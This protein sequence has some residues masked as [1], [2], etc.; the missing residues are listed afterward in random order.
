[1]SQPDL[2]IRQ[3]V[4][5]VLL[6]PS[7]RV[8]LA[9]YDFPTAVVW[10]LPGGGVEADEEPVGALRR[11]LAEELGLVDVEVGPHV[12]NRLHVIPMLD[13]RWD[14]QADQVHLVRTEA[15]TPE[16]QIGWERLNAEYVYELRWWSLDEVLA[17]DAR[18]APRLLGEHLDR[19]LAAGPPDAPIDTG[20]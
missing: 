7:D 4:R 15:F 17:S 19:L 5:A 6:D 16:P 18:F 12:W 9:R 10:A 1:M 20:I 8:L 13:G 2:R 3:A 11:E 14:G